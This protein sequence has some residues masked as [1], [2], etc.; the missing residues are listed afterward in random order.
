MIYNPA[1]FPTTRLRRLRQSPW[2][3][4]LAQE[5]RLHPSDLILPLFIRPALME[6]SIPSLPGILRYTIE[7]AAQQAHEAHAL[8]IQAIA[9][10][11]CVPS[12]NKSIL[13]E[14]SYNPNNLLCQAVRYIK[15]QVPTLGIIT[16]VALDPYTSHGHDGIL[17]DQGDVDNDATLSLLAK[18]AL[19]LAQ[20]GADVIAPSDMMDGRVGL[21]RKTLDQEGYTHTAIL[22]YSAKSA[23]AFYGPF[24]DAVSSQKHLST[25]DKKS[26]QMNYANGLEALREVSLDIAEGADMVMIKPALPYLDIIAKVKEKFSMPTFAYQVSGEYAMIEAAAAH[27]WIDGPAAHYEC[28]LSIKRAGADGIFTYGA[29]KMA[30]RLAGHP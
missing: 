17:N 18:Q 24:R 25:K 21:I 1:P 10:F 29:K 8:G 16:D 11:P 22:A 2:L 7:E 5:T 19:V 27:G 9:L 14:E 12:E 13:A 20:A 30:E 3:R 15:S 23:S 4:E 28:L 6:A 26:Y